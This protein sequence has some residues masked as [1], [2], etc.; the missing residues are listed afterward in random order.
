MRLDELL[1]ECNAPNII[2]FFSL[3]V[4]GSEEKVLTQ[5][6]L[7]KYK[8]LSLC[9]EIPSYNLHTKLIENNGDITSPK[10]TKPPD[11][12][13]TISIKSKSKGL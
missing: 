13:K 7:N 6:V 5:T 8:F 3:D 1:K 4:E 11:I 2:D 9:I 12:N 10:T